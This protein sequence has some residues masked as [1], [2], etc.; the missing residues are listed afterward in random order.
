MSLHEYSQNLV[1]KQSVLV[2]LHSDTDSLPFGTSMALL[3]VSQ[4][5]PFGWKALIVLPSVDG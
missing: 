2:C 4:L 1:T 3:T 5:L